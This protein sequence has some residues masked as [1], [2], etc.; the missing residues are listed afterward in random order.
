MEKTLIWLGFLKNNDNDLCL[1]NLLLKDVVKYILKL[2]PQNDAC[3][4]L[5]GLVKFLKLCV[6]VY[7]KFS[8]THKNEIKKREDAIYRNVA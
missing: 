8:C 4:Q 1:F 3:W 7:Q 5:Q 2:L 6:I